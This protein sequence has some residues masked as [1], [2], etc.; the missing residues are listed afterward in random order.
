MR[1]SLVLIGVCLAAGLAAAADGP[2]DTA[3]VNR[4]FLEH[5]KELPPALAP[6]VAFVEKSWRDEYERNAPGAFVPDALALLYPDFEQ[7]LAAFDAG[8]YEEVESL[9]APLLKHADPF[10]TANA[11]YYA[12]RALVERGRLEEAEARVKSLLERPAQTADFT[13]M[14]PHLWFVRAFTEASNLRFEA[15]LESLAALRARFPDAPEPVTI[16]A[17]QLQIEIERREVGS[18]DQVAELMN[19]SAARL[20]VAD[21]TERVRER[22]AEAVALLDKLIEEAQQREQQSKC[23]GG[24]GGKGGKGQK[25]GATPSPKQG[26]EESN[27]PEGAGQI[28]DLHGAPKADPGEMWGKLPP[29]ERERI[30][31]SLRDRFPSRYRQLVEQYYRS[32]AEEK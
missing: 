14:A 12:V 30:L 6:K 9:A 8:R 22:Q 4:A 11:S 18:L 16:G 15:A 20:R 26:A 23:G 2:R 7:L 17:R 19:Y 32:L 31:Q 29:A 27:A 28:G 25:H 13:P 24:K 21:G 1:R 10:V 5:L 3:A